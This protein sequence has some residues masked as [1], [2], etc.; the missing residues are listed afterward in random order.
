M[1][2]PERKRS[3]VLNAALGDCEIA[4]VEHNVAFLRNVLRDDGVSQRALRHRL[5]RSARRRADSAR[6][7]ALTVAAALILLDAQRTDSPWQR[8]D[9]FRVNLAHEQRLRMRRRGDAI[10]VDIAHD[11]DGYRLTL[12]DRRVRGDR[13]LRSPTAASLR[14]STASRSAVGYVRDGDDLYVMRGGATEKFG[15]PKLDAA[16]FAADAMSDGRGTRADAGSDHRA[17]REGRRHGASRPTD[18]RA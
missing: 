15:M 5:D 2:R 3:S 16:S 18:S 17:V 6:V 10:A 13:G 8:G 1:R 12:D 14:S 11:A 7:A 4:G 9:A